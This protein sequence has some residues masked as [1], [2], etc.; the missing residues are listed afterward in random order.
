[1]RHVRRSNRCLVVAVPRDEWLTSSLFLRMPC[2]GETL[3]C[4]IFET[5]TGAGRSWCEACINLLTRPL[6]MLQFR[7]NAKETDASKVEEQRQVAMKGL[8]QLMQFT[9]LDKKSTTW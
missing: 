8:Q 5:L 3:A 2:D 7:K 9:T 1:M 4:V 6:A